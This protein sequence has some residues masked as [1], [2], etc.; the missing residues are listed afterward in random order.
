MVLSL[1]ATKRSNICVPFPSGSPLVGNHPLGAACGSTSLR[2]A[3]AASVVVPLLLPLPILLLS[4]LSLFHLLP[5]LSLPL[6]LL[7]LPLLS[8]FPLLP[9]ILSLLLNSVLHCYPQHPIPSCF[10]ATTISLMVSS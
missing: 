1:Y 4:L 8:F 6:F 9:L 3:A 2:P 7:C 10:S 5:L